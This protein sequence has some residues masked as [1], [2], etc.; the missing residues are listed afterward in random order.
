MSTN[1]SSLLSSKKTRRL[2]VELAGQVEAQR[3]V[4]VQ[5]VG[6]LNKH[7]EL[8]SQRSLFGRLKWLVLGK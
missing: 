6:S 4:L 2:S 3:E 1:A 5:V 7:I 8:V